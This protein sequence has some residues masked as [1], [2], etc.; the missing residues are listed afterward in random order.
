MH[1][2]LSYRDIEPSSEDNGQESLPINE[3]HSLIIRC[4]VDCSECEGFYFNDDFDYKQFCACACHMREIGI[5][6]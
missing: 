1:I 5:A 2:N 6:K 4:L 3:S